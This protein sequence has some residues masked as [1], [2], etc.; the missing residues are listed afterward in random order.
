MSFS[1]SFFHESILEFF[2]RLNAAADLR[3]QLSPIKPDMTAENIY[4]NV[5]Q[6]IQASLVAQTVKN[7]P[8]T[9]E[10]WV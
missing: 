5:Y 3:I 9:Q 2:N 6:K 4:R 7:L 8:A 10:T 1:F